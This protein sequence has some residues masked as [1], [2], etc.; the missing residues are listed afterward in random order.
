M[1]VKKKKRKFQKKIYDPD[2][3][4]KVQHVN[5]IYALQRE[6]DVVAMILDGR[7]DINIHEYI[8][9]KYQIKP[10]TVAL[11]L[12]KCRKIIRERKIFEADTL[13][14]LHIARYEEIYS[15]LHDIGAHSVAMNALKAKETLLGLHR[16]GFHM[17]VD[18]GEIT[19]IQLQT[20]NSAF[21][22]NKLVGEK[23]ERFEKLI[24][25]ARR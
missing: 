23:R 18:S 1:A 5:R 10:A 6:N 12:A 21:D 8:A 16:E 4:D 20:V 22:L 14:T 11:L 13:I 7:K 3:F 24:N 17:R 9:T 19:A 15:K 25:K 2:H